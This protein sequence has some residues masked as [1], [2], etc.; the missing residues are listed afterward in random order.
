[1]EWFGDALL[2]YLYRRQYDD[3]N[4]ELHYYKS[5]LLPAVAKH[6]RFEHTI[7]LHRSVDTQARSSGRVVVVVLCDDHMKEVFTLDVRQTKRQYN[8]EV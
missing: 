1:M 3:Q 4:L 5:L 6:N 7:L 8:V 2:E